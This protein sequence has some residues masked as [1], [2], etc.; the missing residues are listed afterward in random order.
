[1]SKQTVFIA[2]TETARDPARSG[3]QSV[4]RGAI[5][6]MASQANITLVAWNRRRGYPHPLKPQWISHVAPSANKEAKFLPPDSLCKPEY[7]LT[8]I[9]SWGLNHRAP[10]HRHPIH[11]AELA[12]SWLL[13]PELMDGSDARLMTAYAHA[14][15]M[16]IVAI[17]HDAIPL[18]RPELTLRTPAAHQDYIDA[19]GEMDLVL[20]VSNFSG[21]MFRRF[22]NNGS[23]A[24]IRTVSLPAEIHGAD[25]GLPPPVSAGTIKILCVSTLEPRKN[26]RTLIEAFNMA[27]ATLPEAAM[28]L[29][30]AGDIFRG[31]PEIADFVT[32]AE[33]RNPGIIWHKRV[34]PK[35]LR[36]LYREC[37]F[38]VYPSFIE[39]FGMPVME[40]LWCGRPCLCAN[41]GVMA[42]NAAG[43][44]C[45]TVNVLNPP[46]LS[47]ALVR[48]AT[49]PELRDK[50]TGEAAERPL[51]TWRNY[52][53]ELLELMQK[54]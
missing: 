41:T 49:Q 51:R 22:L 3:I 10:I 38:T 24:N 35:Q 9:Q 33:Q 12:G 28:E 48:L 21:E 32:A 30:L 29:H 19:L 8:W 17:F 42:E 47:E 37:N 31:S 34:Q 46:E 7:W 23:Q 1:M 43:G 18:L 16:K 50:L 36:E 53:A 52:T 14:Q 15:G 2:A 5:R 39:G 40:S 25:R 26:H 45:L 20:P 6:G 44:G 13:L 4:T 54:T 11:Q 27:C